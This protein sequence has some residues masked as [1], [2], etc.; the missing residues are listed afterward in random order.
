MNVNFFIGGLVFGIDGFV[1]ELFFMFNF[2]MGEFKLWFVESGKWVGDNVFE[3]KFRLGLK[4]QDGEFLIVEDVK[5]FYEYYEKI[6]FRNWGDFGFKEIKVVDDR[7]V[8]F[9][10]DGIFNYQFW[11]F[12][13]FFGW[14]QGVFIVLKYVFENINFEDI[15]KMIFIGD[16]MKYFVGF[17]VYKFK[18]VVGQEKVIFERNDDWWGV[19][20]F[21]KF[22]LKYI[23]QFYVIDNNQVVN[24]FIKGDFDVGIYYIDIVL[25]KQKNFKFVSWFDKYFYFLFVVFVFLY[26]N[27][28]YVLFDNLKVRRVIVMVINLYQIVNQGLISDFLKEV[29]FG[30]GFF[31]KWGDKV[32]IDG[33]ISQYGWKYGDVVGVIKFFDEVGVKDIDGDG[34]REYNGKLF[35]FKFVICV[36]CN[37]WFQVGEIIVNQFKVVGIEV[38]IEKGDWIN[39]F[40]KSFQNGDFDFVFYWLGIFQLSVYVV[41]NMFFLKDGGVNYGKY[42]NLQVDQILVEFGKIVDENKEV[43]YIK[44]FCQIWFQDV[45][46]VFVYM[47][48]FFYEVNIEY[49]INWLNEKNFYGVLIFWI[50]YGIWGIV[51]VFFG[52][53]FVNVQEVLIIIIMI[54]E[55]IISKILIFEKINIGLGFIIFLSNGGGICGLVVV[56]GLVVILLLLRRC[57]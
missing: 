26:F 47:V 9:I 17:G 30:F 57:C 50:N 27:I 11:Q 41:F 49:W 39:F 21:G 2:M 33:F 28:K 55:I 45:F 51:F 12:Q 4:W 18:E 3:V 19:K 7:M 16:E 25:V 52:V 37:D 13:M 34:I 22:G 44:Q 42:E 48:M 36:G 40:V 31:K 8:Q 38:E 10:F 32:G 53:K 46:V 54:S 5:F 20:V 43:Q 29:F 23:V 15:F 24:M 6:G 1:F 56:V 35:K 14:G